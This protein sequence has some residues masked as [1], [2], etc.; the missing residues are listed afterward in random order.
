MRSTSLLFPSNAAQPSLGVRSRYSSQSH[1][2]VAL[3][4]GMDVFQRTRQKAVQFGA[5]TELHLA[6]AKGDIVAL[7]KALRDPDNDINETDDLGNN[8]L[9][10]AAMEGSPKAA[11]VVRVLLGRPGILWQEPNADGLTPRQLAEE[12]DEDG[13]H[14][15]VINEFK[16]KA[17]ESI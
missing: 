5:Y 13:S 17:G 10:A 14:Q 16:K 4:T 3:Y 11:A 12:E 6:A 2:S 15:A 1:A 9:H 8:A 7:H